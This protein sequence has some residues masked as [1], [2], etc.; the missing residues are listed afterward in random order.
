MSRRHEKRAARGGR[1]EGGAPPPEAPCPLCLRPIPPGARASRHHLVPRLKGGTHRGTVRLH[2]IC[3]QA[4]YARFTETELARRFTEP[5]AL[6]AE[7]RLAD[8]LAWVSTKPP[9]F[10]A[11]TR[12]ARDRTPKWR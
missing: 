1:E 9:D 2:H 6:R 4:I 8:F 12:A 11:P 5:E 7:P 3:H 10:H